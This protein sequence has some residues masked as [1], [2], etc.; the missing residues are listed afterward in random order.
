[1]RRP[2]S[3]WDGDLKEPI[4]R[5]FDTNTAST[6]RGKPGGADQGQVVARCTV[7]HLI[8]ELGIAGAVR[9]QRVITTLPG[10]AE[11]APDLLDRD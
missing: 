7:E 4:Q 8:R 10:Q 11:R 1:M 6:G 2:R 5:V 3:V 9:G